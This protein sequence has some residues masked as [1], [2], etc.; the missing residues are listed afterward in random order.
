M[1]SIKTIPNSTKGLDKGK[2]I[3]KLYYIFID[4]TCVLLIIIFL[5]KN[6]HEVHYF[7]L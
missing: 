7:S 6:R 1:K 2:I 3:N 4:N 5:E